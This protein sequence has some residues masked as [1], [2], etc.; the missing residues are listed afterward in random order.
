MARLRNDSDLKLSFPHA[1]E[2]QA[3]AVF[4]LLFE[5][6]VDVSA[7]DMVQSLGKGAFDLSFTSVAV[8]R[9]VFQ[10]LRAKPELAVSSYGGDDVVVIT[11][12]SIP[13]SLDDGVVRRWLSQFCTVQSARFCT[14]ISHPTVKNGHRQ[15]RVVLK[16][17]RHVPGVTYMGGRPVFFRYV[18]Q[19]L[20]CGK[21]NEVGHIARDCQ[22]IVCSKCRGLGHRAPDCPNEVRCSECHNTGHVARACTVSS[23]RVKM[24]SSWTAVVKASLATAGPAPAVKASVLPAPGTSSSPGEGAEVM[25]GSPPPLEEDDKFL[26]EEDD[27][28]AA[29]AS[30]S[31]SSRSGSDWTTVQRKKKKKRKSPS[32]T[33]AKGRAASFELGLSASGLLGSAAKSAGTSDIVPADAPASAGPS[34]SAAVEAVPE[35]VRAAVNAAAV[36]SDASVASGDLFVDASADVSAGRHARLRCP[37]SPAESV[38]DANIENM[39]QTAYQ[40]NSKRPAPLDDQAEAPVGNKRRSEPL[41]RSGSQSD[42]IESFDS[43]IRVS[44]PPSPVIDVEEFSSSSVE[45]T[46]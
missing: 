5:E 28:A 19:P 38:F 39:Q 20:I 26:E 10:A 40:S 14:Y 15:Y 31:D 22:H 34:S 37:L 4:D 42:D 1:P 6:K 35:T 27:E 33:Q 7:I 13:G 9:R 32:L 46:V 45:T 25:T 29:D 36:L 8:R 30:G 18:G 3:K 24:S 21:C 16:A 2:T 44:L 43:P 11:A 17:G 12:T 41:R 23:A